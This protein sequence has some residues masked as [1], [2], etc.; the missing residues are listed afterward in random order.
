MAD[1][2]AGTIVA[3]MKA[4]GLFL[5]ASWDAWRAVLRAIFALPMSAADLDVYRRVTGRTTAPTQPFREVW[6]DHRS[7]WRQV[8]HHRADRRLGNN[9]PHVQARGR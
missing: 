7:P 4:S 8:H 2:M 3:L 5:G 9:V 1:A 6:L